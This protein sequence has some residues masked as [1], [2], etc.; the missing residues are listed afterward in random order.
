MLDLYFI[1]SCFV[2]CFLLSIGHY[3][4]SVHAFTINNNES[5]KISSTLAYFLSSQ[6]TISSFG[7]Y[8]TWPF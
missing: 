3:I 8:Y 6:I 5:N 2:V 4:G 7:M 1:F